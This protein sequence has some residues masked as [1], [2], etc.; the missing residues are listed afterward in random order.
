MHNPGNYP[1]RKLLLLTGR[2]FELPSLTT[3]VEA[4]DGRRR[5]I[6]VPAG[7]IVKVASGP[8][9]GDGLVEVLWDDRTLAMCAVDLDGRATEIV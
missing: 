7:A 3:A 4:I 5:V 8:V 9:N 2:R 1:A 6:T